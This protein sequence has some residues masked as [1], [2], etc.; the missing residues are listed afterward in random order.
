M[1]GL[2]NSSS[3]KKEEKKK[4]SGGLFNPSTS[5]ASTSKKSSGGGLFKPSSTSSPA[6]NALAPNPLMKPNPFDT[7]ATDRSIANA[8]LRIE[9]SGWA[10]NPDKRNP[11]EKAL[12][13]PQ[14]QNWFFDTLDVL[15][16]PQQ[17]LFGGMDAILKTANGTPTDRED[18][19]MKGLTGKQKVR[20]SDLM[21]GLGVTNKPT[22]AV[23]G[24][25]ADVATDPLNLIPGKLIGGAVK[26]T[27]G[28][29]KKGLDAAES[30]APPLKTLRETK[31]QPALEAGKDALGRIFVPKYKW[32]ETLTGGS[33]P[34][35]KD[36][37]IQ[38]END[39]RYMTDEALKGITDAA[40]KS[41]G[42]DT[43]TDVG[44]IMEKDLRQFEDNP[45]FEFPDGVRRTTSKR[46]LDN[47]IIGNKQRIKELGQ[48]VRE[49]N[50]AMDKQ[51]SE[52]AQ[53]LDKNDN[54]LRRMFMSIEN[55]KLKS[56]QKTDPKALNNPKVMPGFLPNSPALNL[57]IK[58]QDETKAQID[59]MRTELGLP[60]VRKKSYTPEE[61]QK[62]ATDRTFKQLSP[63]PAFNLLL[64][65]SKDF[66]AELDELREL[67]K[68][69]GQQ[70]IADIQRLVDENAA[71]KEAAKNP[72]MVPRE[73]PRP[74][75]D[76][77]TDAKI[78][79]AADTL[80][81]SNDD[82][83]QW[84]TA[85]GI[86][87]GEIEGYMRH[88]LSAEEQAAR[89]IV[90][91]NA[92]D[93]SSASMNNPSKSILKA[94][95][96]TGSVE[97]INEQIGRKFF[98]PNA[99][100]AS[101]LGQK[102]LIEYGNAVNFRREVLSNPQFA[103]PYVPGKSPAPGNGQTVIN[104][105]NYKFLN[106]PTNPAMADEI[107][108]DYVVT[109]GVKQALDRYQKLTSDEGI[110][111]FLKAYD[112]ATSGWKKLT[113]L[114]PEYH[115]RND[116]GAKFNNY[117]G[118]MNPVDIA[119]YTA[120]ATK[121]VTNALARSKNTP[122]YNEFKQQGLGSNSQL[123]VEFARHGND[124]EKAFREVV[125]D[126]SRTALQKGLGTINPLRVFKTS[127]QLGTAIDQINRFAL[128]KWARETKG[129]NP[130]QAADKV[131][132]V[133]FDYSDLT[134]TEREL[135]V[136]AVPF[137][138][139]SRNNIPFQIKQLVTNPLKYE[140]VNKAKEEA[141]NYFGMDPEKE[142]DFTKNSFA[143]PVSGDGL[144]TGSMLGLNLPLSDLTKLNEPAKLFAD[145]L[146][147]VIKTP[148][149]LGTN[150]NLFKGRDIEQFKGEQKKMQIPEK[151]LGLNVP[152]G[153]TP[154]GGIPVK[155]DHALRQLGGNPARQFLNAATIKTER[156]KEEAATKPAFG[157]T[158][159]LKRYDINETNFYEKKAELRRL[160]ELIDYI[161]QETGNRPKSVTDIKKGR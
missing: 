72:V 70:E 63:S 146:S 74:V 77:T 130:R 109:S 10:V 7:A 119:K 155:T 117:V 154:L 92:V 120:S 8:K 159:M 114:S 121:D 45:M 97:D 90:K 102:K 87:V 43:G 26:E 149:E 67:R 158:N 80:I 18:A 91:P 153:G 65:R 32:D 53:A 29:F 116:L 11:V 81:K 135:F 2:F 138:R 61:M 59:D 111:A 126:E 78:V 19:F 136:R 140:N 94:R 12:N 49:T 38:T 129:M 86:P 84:A 54:A 3:T 25:I 9:N 30:V 57:L 42:L 33:D 83:R 75:R 139:W 34:F 36:R 156:E 21:Q 23:T 62:L 150:Y 24:F 35:L 124:A 28:L 141:Q 127:Q 47:E 39:I 113:L 16:R 56:L 79:Q 73:I 31:V 137:Y 132:E 112:A 134:P 108:G 20:G 6:T 95:K 123:A 103:R 41:G 76:M 44:R 131:K 122:L 148:I 98:E 60:K 85:N 71:I 118:G 13:L 89:K 100:F 125:K 151:I 99:F 101:A 88:I 82:I 147:P 15:N 17:A 115:V 46:E 66:K 14:D 40:R 128:Y 144:G 104:T 107:G 64:Q 93:R 105:N 50:K 4:T 161:E 37:Y 152:G 96:L 1:P 69:S 52:V 160:M 133:Q 110:H 48:G 143:F 27:G 5:S 58:I 22:K 145:S 142:S 68:T 157:I 51:I 106:D 55:K